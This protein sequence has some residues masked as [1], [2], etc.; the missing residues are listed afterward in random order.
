[1]QHDDKDEDSIHAIVIANDNETKPDTRRTRSPLEAGRNQMKPDEG[2]GEDE[3]DD[4]AAGESR[5]RKPKTKTKSTT[6]TTR[7]RRRRMGFPGW[8]VEVSI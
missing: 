5:R 2:K 4:E 6:E 7:S 1:M 8:H 3:G